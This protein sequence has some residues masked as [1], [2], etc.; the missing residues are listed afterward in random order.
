MSFIGR[1]RGF[2][3]AAGVSAFLLG[4]TSGL[5]MAESTITWGKPA[6]IT[7]GDVHVAGTASSWDVFQLVYET[8][9][10][11]D[12]TLALKPGLAESWEQTSPTTYVFTLRE[13]AAFSNGRRVE[14]ADVVG[15]F[16][17]IL[18]PATA[19]YWAKQ[20]G[21]VKEVKALDERRVQ[22]ELE[23]PHTAF[24]PAT[25]HISAAIIPAKELLAGE[26]DPV[27]EMMGTGPFMVVEHKQDESWTFAANP[28]YWREGYPLADRLYAPIIPDEAARMAALRDGRIDYTFFG[29]PDIELL[30]ARDANVTVIAQETTN[31][32]RV[33]VNA[34][35]PERPFH[36]K[37]VRQ[38]MDLALDRNAIRELV[39][40]GSAP[41]DFP[42]PRAF[43]LEACKSNPAYALPR[44]ERLEKARALLAEAGTP[45][46]E[47]AIMAT[48]ANPLYA[49]IAQV[50]QQ[51]MNE[52][53]FETSIE[54]VPVADWLQRVFTD[55]DFDLS[56]S[57]LA[58]YTDPTMVISWWNPKFAVWNLAFFEDVPALDT[59]LNDVKKMPAGADRDAKL[60]EICA[61]IGDGAN[62]LALVNKVDYVAYRNDQIEV[63]ID[64][65]TGS[66]NM[67]QHIGEFNSLKQ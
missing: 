47:V 11:T 20:F 27:T 43:G 7:F 59:A 48:T 60:D 5:A 14:P 39:F 16:N 18:D 23:E 41:V 32:Y 30:F 46:P 51:S 66:S 50:M 12:E 13:N 25:A 8:L 61:M 10:T 67:F 45:A 63:R 17:R 57:W 34:L 28:H 40:A 37:R 36:D 55:A 42:V 3:A 6:E 19:S 53:G 22:V 64:P 35:N 26:F 65:K 33:D 31:Y 1:T 44:N 15:S 54:Q 9:L 21:T 29:N 49:R 4:S 2:L 24:L 52:A 62:L 38:A 56:V 58:G